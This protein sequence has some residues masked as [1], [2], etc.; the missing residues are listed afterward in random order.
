MISKNQISFV[1]SLHQKKFRQMYG[2]FLVEGEKMVLELLSSPLRVDTVFSTFP[3]SLQAAHSATEFV[4][5]SDNDLSK[6][7]TQSNPDKC[8]AVVNMPEPNPISDVHLLEQELFVVC[9]NIA[10]PGNAGT[11]IR[12]A[13]WFGISK[14]FFSL[15]SVDLYNPK[16]VAASKGSLFRVACIHTD[17]EQLLQ[18]NSHL[19]V[20][21]SF[22]HGENI[23]QA[24]LP[25]CGF[26]VIGNEAN[27]IGSAIEKR[28]THRITI[29]SFGKAESLNAGVATGILLSE[30][31]RLQRV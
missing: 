11:I 12:T 15:N 21:G 29:P 6:I 23:Y 17:I 22:M 25:D 30:F 7:A 24:K 27:G 8:L 4:R 1:R 26:I 3:I 20:I 5:V 18:S 9:D 16:T 14:V 2:K 10:D 31:K 13:D 19:P 28:V